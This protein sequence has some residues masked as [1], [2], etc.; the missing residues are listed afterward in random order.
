MNQIIV[1]G[2]RRPLQ[3]TRNKSNTV[4]IKIDGK[5]ETVSSLVEKEK[6]HRKTILYRYRN[7]NRKY[8]RDLLP[9]DIFIRE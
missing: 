2:R 4:I 1:N 8:I 6:V 5:W 3:Q 7:H 9:D